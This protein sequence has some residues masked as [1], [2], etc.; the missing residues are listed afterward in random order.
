MYKGKA[1]TVR[2]FI[3]ESILHPSVYVTNGYPDNTMPKNYGC[4]INA[5]A[6]DKMVDYLAEVKEGNIP[7]PIK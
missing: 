1:T 3:T 7:P 4:K 2:E 5:L 6:L